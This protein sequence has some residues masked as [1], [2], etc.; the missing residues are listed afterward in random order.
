VSLPVYSRSG[1][2]FSNAKG[3]PLCR[4]YSCLTAARWKVH[5]W[6]MHVTLAMEECCPKYRTGG[7]E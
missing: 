4:L 7:S 1:G 2:C 3:G 5:C 6:Q